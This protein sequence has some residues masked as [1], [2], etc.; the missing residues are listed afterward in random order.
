ML[1]NLI[2]AFTSLILIT[3]TAATQVKTPYHDVS[4][5]DLVAALQFRGIDIFKFNIDS[6][7][8]NLYLF[9]TVDEY[10]S[11]HGLQRVDTLLV[12][13]T[14]YT[15]GSRPEYVSQIRFITSV[16]NSDF[17]IIHVQ[18]GTKQASSIK[19]LTILPQFAKKHYWARFVEQP[20]V[21]GKSIPLL[22]FGSEWSESIRG[23]PTTRPIGSKELDPTLKD[24]ALRLVP[25]YFIIA[26][27]LR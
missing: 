14:L 4:T 8:K 9:I 1:K 13:Q 3:S 5:E 11:A 7:R 21:V 26:Y 27:E 12:G 22:F 18:T 19:T 15:E 24:S 25:H 16:I 10:D 6:Q 23:V 2:F 20:T 17:R